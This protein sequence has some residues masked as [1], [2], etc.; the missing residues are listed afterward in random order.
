MA[1]SYCPKCH[2]PEKVCLCPWLTKQGNQVAV[3][4]LQHPDEVKKAIGTASIV[5]LSL[6]RCT[7]TA[8][9][10]PDER[11]IQNELKALQA[12]QP[13]LIYPQA[14]NDTNAHY[15]Y[16]FEKDRFTSSPLQKHYDCII[17]LDG[18]WRNTR[19][20]LHCNPWLRR[21]PTLELKNAEASRYRIRQAQKSGA[22]ATIE[23]VA[24]AL[25]VLADDVNVDTLLLP[26]E[27]MIALQ[28]EQMGQA[29]FEKNYQSSIG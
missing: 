12:S 27:K 2:K 6:E 3:L 23:A 29:V 20:I 15:M 10:K 17:L 26:F 14:L 19:E 28:I 7:I 22:L 4:I 8:E 21:F 1:R 16:D 25:T 24:K 11:L 18:T 9:L 13:L 5:K